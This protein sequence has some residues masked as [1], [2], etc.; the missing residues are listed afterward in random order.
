MVRR[1]LAAMDPS[2]TIAAVAT[3]GELVDANSPGIDST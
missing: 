1:T 3:I 2:Q